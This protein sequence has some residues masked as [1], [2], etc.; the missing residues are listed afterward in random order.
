MEQELV[1]E[2]ELKQDLE[3]QLEHWLELGQLLALD[4]AVSRDQ[5]LKLEQVYLEMKELVLPQDLE[6]KGLELS[7]D[8]ER[9]GLEFPQALGTTAGGSLLGLE[10]ILGKEFEQV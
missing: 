2:M 10:E 8:R 6:R 3:R 4:L 5:E 1:L 9:M 7:L